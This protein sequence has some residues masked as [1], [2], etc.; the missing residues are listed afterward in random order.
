MIKVQ[1]SKLLSFFDFVLCLKQVR[2]SGWVFKAGISTPESVADHSFSLCMMAMVLSDLR[3]LNTERAIKMAMLHDL[4]ESII[5][6]IMPG[7]ISSKIKRNLERKAMIS[8]LNNLPTSLYLEYHGIWKE[9]LDQR[10]ALSKFVHRLDKL[11][12]VLQAKKY[13]TR[14]YSK[15][16][17]IEMINSVSPILKCE[18][19]DIVSEVLQGLNAASLE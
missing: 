6:D 19:K 9:Y 10:T 18:R 4:S 2:R 14:G 11:E 5:G 16:K 12:M 13:V 17:L 8:I 15:N 3:G 7:Q 1:L